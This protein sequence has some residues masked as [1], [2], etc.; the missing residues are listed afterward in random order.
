[1][2]MMLQIFQLDI[3]V[4][5]IAH[6]ES[7]SAFQRHGT[8]KGSAENK[9]HKYP[10]IVNNFQCIHICK[11]NF[12]RKVNGGNCNNNENYHM[13]INM[14]IIG[15]AVSA[16]YNGYIHKNS[17]AEH[18]IFLVIMNSLPAGTVAIYFSS[19]LHYALIIYCIIDLIIFYII[20]IIIF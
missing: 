17:P 20:Q 19:I 9:M 18:E 5:Q 1:M 10:R 4:N 15:L 13:N 2:Q 14:L 7:K 8:Q 16:K 3:T 11:E 6:I 12:Q